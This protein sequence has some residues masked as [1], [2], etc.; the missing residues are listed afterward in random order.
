MSRITHFELVTDDEM[1]AALS[2]MAARGINVDVN[3]PIIIPLPLRPVLSGVAKT[4]VA[5]SAS[6]SSAGPAKA[7][8]GFFDSLA[9]LTGFIGSTQSFFSNAIAAPP[10]VT[11]TD[12]LQNPSQVAAFLKSEAWNTAAGLVKSGQ[13]EAVSATLDKSLSTVFGDFAPK[14][15]EGGYFS[16]NSLASMGVDKLLD[17]DGDTLMKSLGL[18]NLDDTSSAAT[19]IEAAGAKWALSELKPYLKSQVLGLLKD[20]FFGTTDSS[21]SSDPGIEDR[22][23]TA[24]GLDDDAGCV[25]IAVRLDSADHEGLIAAPCSPTVLAGGMPVARLGDGFECARDAVSAPIIEGIES[26]LVEG[27]PIAPNLAKTACG[28]KIRASGFHQVW[29]AELHFPLSPPVADAE[30]CSNAAPVTSDVPEVDVDGPAGTASAV[31]ESLPDSDGSDNGGLDELHQRVDRLADS[32][33]NAK[34]ELF[35]WIGAKMDLSNA[36][37]RLSEDQAFLED[38]QRAHEDANDEL[39]NEIFKTAP[40]GQAISSLISHTPAGVDP[41]DAAL[42]QASQ[43][44]LEEEAERL[45]VFQAPAVIEAIGD[46]QREKVAQ[47]AKQASDAQDR[48]NQAAI[49]FSNTVLEMIHETGDLILMPLDQPAVRIK[50]TKTPL[51]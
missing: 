46:T 31:N 7:Q 9:Q 3:A 33:A 30:I 35:A 34:D 4:A 8:P 40:G 36:Q 11:F 28:A 26:V 49:D 6:G 37:N 32:A 23:R 13:D 39:T 1:A 14:N 42:V 12:F 21:A 2:R 25:P 29:V 45:R 44:P 20:K 41:F 5:N 24:L 43:T 10:N 51:H 16:V 47:S 38:I 19:Q 18:M 22:L 50:D 48:E 27:Q 15:D 17:F